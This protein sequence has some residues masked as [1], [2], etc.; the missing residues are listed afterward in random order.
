MTVERPQ[1]LGESEEHSRQKEKYMKV[2]G[3]DEEQKSERLKRE[4]VWL[5]QRKSN[6]RWVLRS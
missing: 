1:G 2:L 3:Q 4:L 5:R 6:R